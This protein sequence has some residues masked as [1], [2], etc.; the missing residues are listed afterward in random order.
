MERILL[1]HQK[2]KHSVGIEIML[3]RL[4]SRQIDLFD[5]I[6]VLASL[7]C[8]INQ[9]RINAAYGGKRAKTMD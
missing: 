6:C 4:F 2:Y 8:H 9:A 3:N 1:L 5:N 7:S